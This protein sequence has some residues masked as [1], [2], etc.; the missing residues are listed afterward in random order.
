LAVKK[1]RLIA[2]G[3]AVTAGVIISSLLSSPVYG[4]FLTQRSVTLRT[5]IAGA[6]TDYTIRF[7]ITTPASLGSIRLQF[8]EDTPFFNTPCAAPSGFDMSSSSL[9]SQTGETGF[10]V[11]GSST[12]NDI[13]LTRVAAP[14]LAGPVVFDF[15]DVI[16]PTTPNTTTYLRIL[17]YPTTDGTGVSTDQGAAAFVTAGQFGTA[18]YVP[19]LLYF[20][21][22]ITVAPDCSSTTGD[23]GDFG[24]LLASQTASLTSQAAAATND[25]TGYVLYTM[26]TTMTSGNNVIPSTAFPNPSV[27]GISRFGINL[28]DNN[29]PNIGQD[30]TGSGS[31]NVL[32]NYNT[33][34]LFMFD[35]GAPIAE[36]TE[37]TD[38]NVYTISYIT[39]VSPAQPPGIYVTTITYLA[40]AQ[41]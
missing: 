3:L 29:N 38:F 1:I 37:A 9:V 28:R 5:P 31:G 6:V 34:N 39:N 11:H 4:A 19:P 24:T 14:S 32:L 40:V 2:Y 27:S 30:I 17:T 36:A 41:F 21:V 23:R 20:C 25:P 8:C 26:G 10:S 7:R 33:P 18:A 16:N 12:D 13:V 35:P 22:G 15:E